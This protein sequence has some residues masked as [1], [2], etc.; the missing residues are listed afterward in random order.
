VFDLELGQD[1]FTSPTRPNRLWG[2]PS[3]LF[4]AKRKAD[5]LTSHFTEVNNEWSYTSTLKHFT[6]LL[7]RTVKLRN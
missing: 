2:L 1:F 7:F 3:V 5:L 6:A 4:N